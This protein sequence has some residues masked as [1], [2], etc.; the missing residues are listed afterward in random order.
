MIVTI[1]SCMRWTVTFHF[2][3]E[4]EWILGK[5][6]RAQH[7]K[8]Q[9]KTCELALELELSLKDVEFL[10]MCENNIIIIIT[11]TSHCSNTWTYEQVS[12][13]SICE[14][15]VDTWLRLYLDI[16]PLDIDTWLFV[17]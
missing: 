5:N 13:S 16:R 12:N 4:S 10:S 11:I 2:S 17:P 7:K 9:T 14:I 8:H 15:I 6:V 3:I 1:T